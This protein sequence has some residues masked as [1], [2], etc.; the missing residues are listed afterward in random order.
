M[1]RLAEGQPFFQD[2]L[3]DPRLIFINKDEEGEI[4]SAL[5]QIG[6]LNSF[7]VIVHRPSLETM[8]STMKRLRNAINDFY[9]RK[10]SIRFFQPEMD[11]NVKY[12]LA[13]SEKFLPAGKLY[14]VFDGIPVAVISAGPSLEPSLPLLVGLRNRLLI[15]SV[16]TALQ[17]L[18]GAGVEPDLVMVTDPQEIVW[19][20]LAGV[21]K[22]IPLVFLPTT[23]WRVMES[24]PG[25]RLAAVQEGLE[26]T[27]G[28]SGFQQWPLL[29][30]GG[31]V[32]TAALDLAIKMG[33]DPVIF[34]GQDLGYPRGLTHSPGVMYHNTMA[35]ETGQM[36]ESIAGGCIPTGRN[37]LLYKKWIED[38][39]EREKNRVFIN[40]SP[41]GACIRGTCE[42]SLEELKAGFQRDKKDFP[43]MIREALR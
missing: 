39:I 34:V 10:N 4:V 35:H 17:P 25:P 41:W 43:A 12:F 31:S 21:N 32:S 28:L 40:T 33:A 24:W 27:G 14:G 7:Q 8:P 6:Q 2:L 11:K 18:L 29:E 36:V 42:V 1:T 3:K 38:R 13:H 9:I 15:L 5:G 30:T 22:D 19:Q 37:L 16:G 23:S 26:M 20:Q